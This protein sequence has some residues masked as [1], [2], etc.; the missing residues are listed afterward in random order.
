MKNTIENTDHS[1]VK[2]ALNRAARYSVRG[3][4]GRARHGPVLKGLIPA[5]LILLL[6]KWLVYFILVEEIL[7][8][9]KKYF[10][11]VLSVLMPV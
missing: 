11:P 6:A 5:L 2:T 8:Q 7:F 10:M 9:Y 1:A 4:L 3:L